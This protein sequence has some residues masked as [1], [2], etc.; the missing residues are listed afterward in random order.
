MQAFCYTSV[1]M[2]HILQ[3]VKDR[4]A[5]Q[6][7]SKTSL[8]RTPS[9]SDTDTAVI[10]VSDILPELG[11]PAHDLIQIG[12]GLV[13]DSECHDLAKALLTRSTDML[14]TPMS[15]ENVEYIPQKVFVANH[16]LGEFWFGYADYFQEQGIE[17]PSSL[18]NMMRLLYADGKE[19]FL[20]A[21]NKT[22]LGLVATQIV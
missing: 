1:A 4:L 2:K 12:A 13:M 8:L 21:K 7:R 15:F 5:K 18:L 10:I 20:V 3:G 9:P 17:I 6:W 19:T 16:D 22:I 14:V 11:T